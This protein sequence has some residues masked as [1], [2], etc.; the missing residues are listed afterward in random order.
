GPAAA[1]PSCC[2]FPRRTLPEAACKVP[3]GLMRQPGRLTKR[4]TPGLVP[5]APGLRFR[6]SRRYMGAPRSP[7]VRYRPAEEACEPHEPAVRG[8]GLPLDADRHGEPA[9]A[10]RSGAGRG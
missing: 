9:A 10:A 5:D 1:R 3:A 4:A 7:A 2:A 6:A 8:T